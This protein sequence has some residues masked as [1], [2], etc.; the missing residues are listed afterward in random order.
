MTEAL[1]TAIGCI[2]S[3]EKKGKKGRKLLSGV[4]QI[5]FFLSFQIW[6][7]SNYYLV[8]CIGI[9]GREGSEKSNRAN[10]IF[11]GGKVELP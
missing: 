7:I 6:G 11:L 5:I 10:D 4:W 1:A 3:T 9:V 8:S 2:Y